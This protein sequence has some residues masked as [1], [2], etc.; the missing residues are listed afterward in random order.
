M[1]F[2]QQM[3]LPVELTLRTAADGPR[4]FAQPVPELSS[5][6]GQ[7]HASAEL[8]LA[9]GANPLGDLKGDLFEVSVDF[10]PGTAQ[11]FE[12]DLRGTPLVY[13]IP[14]Q[15]LTCKGVKTPLK[16][17]NGRVRLQVYVDRGSIEVFGN[18]GRVAMSIGAIPQDAYRSIGV[19]SR[20]GAIKVGSLVVHELRSAWGRP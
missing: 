5:L 10:S 14:K 6:R 8:T 2:N 19:S 17:E 16:A 15:E 18:D 13:D 3:V 4:L 7:K 1:P 11:T 20:G 12:L 9:P